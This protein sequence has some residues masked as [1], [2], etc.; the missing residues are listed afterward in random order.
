MLTLALLGEATIALNGKPLTGIGSRTAEALLI[1]LACE[2]RPFS[3]H[4]L[5]EFFW[6]E[7]DPEQSAANLRAALSLLRKQVGDYL[8]V[9][10]QTIAFNQELP[11]QLDTAAFTAVSG[12]EE[13]AAMETAVALYR[14]DF[15]DGFYLRESRAFEEWSLLK[16]EQFQ[17]QAIQ[18]LR[19][20]LADT[21]VAQ[22]PAASLTY[23]SHLLRLNPLSEY[24]HQQKITALARSGQRQ[25]ALRQYQ[26]CQRLLREELGLEP[27][28]EITELAQRLQRAGQTARHNLPPALTPFVGRAQELA[29]LER[30]LIDPHYR[31]LTL[32]GPGGVGKTRLALAAAQRLIATGYFLNGL[33]FV[34]L[35]NADTPAVL[36][37]L[38]A[39][40]MGLTFNGNTPPA[41]QLAAALAGEEMLL[42]L[43][44]MEH[45]MTGV[46]G[47][48]T[49]DFLAHLLARAPLLTLL[50]TSRRRLQLQEEWLFDVAGL[51]LPEG[52]A[53][54]AALATDVA[55]AADA[56]QLFLQMATRVQRQFQPTP[57]DLTVIVYLCQRLEGLPLGIELAAGW[58]RHLSCPE[59]GQKLD[60]SISLLATDLRNVPARQ[61]SMTAVFDY[62]WALLP[63]P[64]QVVLARLS[65][66]QSGFT[67]AAAAAIA[68]A[69][70]ME[71]TMLVEH[72]LL[73]REGDGRYAQHTLLR[74]LSA[75]RLAPTEQAATAEALAHYYAALLQAQEA[76]LDGPQANIL[77][78]DLRHDGANLAAAWAWGL[79]HQAVDLL[80]QMAGGLAYLEETQGAFQLGYERLA[81]VTGEWL[82]VTDAGQLLA[83]RCRAYQGRFAHQLGRFEE[84]EVLYRESVGWL[85]PLPSTPALALALTH[86][87]ELARQ[88]GDL[89]AARSRHEESLALFRHWGNAPGIARALL[90]L[91]NLAFVSGQLPEAAR[92]YEEGLAICQ[93]L[94]SYRQTA[95]FQD[96]LGAVLIELG[97]YERAEQTLTAALTRRQ[98]IND[99]WGLAT[100][101][102]NLGVL[103]GLRGHYNE[104][105]RRYRAAADAYRRIGYAF[106][107]ARCLTNLGSMFI[108]QGELAEAQH[109]LAQA[110]ALWQPLN[111][112]EGEADTLLCLGQAASKQG[113]YAEAEGL[114]RQSAALYRQCNRPIPLLR[115]LAD[116]SVVLGRLVRQ[117]EARAAL[118]E[119]LA[120]AEAA[121]TPGQLWGVMAGADLAA[122]AGKL[123][124]AAAWFDVVQR[125]PQTTQPVRDEAARL[126]QS[127]PDLPPPSDHAPSL[128]AALAALG[129][130]LGEPLLP[131]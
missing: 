98:A 70:E 24:A 110:L 121:T 35:V 36:P 79:A 119:S 95:V 99:Q 12:A 6:E 84:A 71:L 103:A 42:I 17:Q 40:E 96:N 66:F 124:L 67:A 100:S 47:E 94:G 14:G 89:A 129:Q 49:A 92:Q 57:T 123:A 101:N 7:R 120:L 91:A 28:L 39:A 105:I 18:L 55:L 34:S 45:L 72:S 20:L 122:Q 60:K 2:A 108:S 65:L 1:F 106:G 21:A 104:A 26:Q 59:I 86:W 4:Y 75:T 38:I 44:N 88:Q 107:V 87:G 131:I 31:L 11:Y 37:T 85:R 58:L 112:P 10:R 62:S 126:R 93:Q 33:R 116:L 125:H 118:V 43:D 46:A 114:L 115:V 113:Q 9:N 8:A 127:W 77:L 5:A 32:I 81:A 78:A 27:N 3:R 74:Q 13:L 51:S 76:Q 16:R 22:N 111:S 50:V 64:A 97:E 63:V 19:R 25:A 52:E 82:A 80:A 128:A 117:A 29:D 15:L 83:G 61:R 54:D 56:V 48:E 68:G 41:E 69:T 102:N 73:R 130:F 23:A 90:H 53:A 109:Y 30:H